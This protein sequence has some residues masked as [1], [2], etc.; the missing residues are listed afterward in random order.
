VRFLAWLLT[1]AVALAVAAWLFDG[2]YFDGPSS[3]IEEIKHKFLPLLLVAVIMGSVNAVVRP[4]ITLLSLPFVILT[5]GLFLFLVNAAMLQFTDW[6]AG[7]FG[8][9]FHVDG[10]WTAIGGAIVITIVTW[11]ME[12]VLRDN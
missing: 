2:I 3:G 10:F 9:G 6:L 11:G 1:N 12:R 4:V 8:L 7:L 5:L